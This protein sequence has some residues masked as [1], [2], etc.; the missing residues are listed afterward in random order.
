MNLALIVTS[1][2]SQFAHLGY[3]V[4]VAP[5]VLAAWGDEGWGDPAV[6]GVVRDGPPGEAKLLGQLGAGDQRSLIFGHSAIV[7]AS[8]GCRC[9]AC[10][11]STG[12]P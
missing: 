10:L 1:L 3:D 8:N 5:A 12:I 4:V 6:L 9:L 7:C 2:F 11:D